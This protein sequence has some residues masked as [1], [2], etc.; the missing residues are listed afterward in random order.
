MQDLPTLIFVY[1]SDSAVSV[2][3]SE[4]VLHLILRMC[5][6]IKFYINNLSIACHSLTDALWLML[7]GNQY[8]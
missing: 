4:N 7:I 5:T 3:V 1:F 6:A 2:R 8:Q